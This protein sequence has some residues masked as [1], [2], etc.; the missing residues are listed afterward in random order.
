MGKTIAASAL[1]S[2]TEVAKIDHLVYKFEVY[3]VLMGVSSKR[4]EEFAPHTACR[5]GKWYYEGEGRECFSKLP[6]YADLEK[7]HKDFHTAALAAL[8]AHQKGEV[9]ACFA[10]IA[11][12]ETESFKVLETL[13]RLAASAQ[14]SPAWSCRSA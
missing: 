5:L 12:M 1:R 2:F 9:D 3:R 8:A 10:H 13:E 14:S 7:P 11:E 4:I 6:G